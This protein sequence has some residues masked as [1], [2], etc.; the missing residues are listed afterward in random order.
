MGIIVMLG[1]SIV[2][3][4]R[5]RATGRSG[6]LW[7]MLV[8][9]VGLAVGF[10]AAVGGTLLDLVTASDSEAVVPFFALW[11]MAIGNTLGSIAIAA[12]AGH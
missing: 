11:G 9:I 6:M 5:A 3:F 7:V 4:R 2:A 8:W 1:A 10:M 12:R